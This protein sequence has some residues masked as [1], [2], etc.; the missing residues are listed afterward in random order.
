MTPPLSR[1]IARA[2]PISWGAGQITAC[3]ARLY[4]LGY[5]LIGLAVVL[6]VIAFDGAK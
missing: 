6:I 5:E 1:Y 4:K 2:R 3:W